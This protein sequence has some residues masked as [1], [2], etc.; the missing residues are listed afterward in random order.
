MLA[1]LASSYT[2]SGSK[3]AVVT[4]V[5]YSAQRSPSAR[6]FKS[7][8]AAMRRRPRSGSLLF[9]IFNGHDCIS[10]RRHAPEA[11]G[12]TRTF[13]FGLAEGSDSPTRRVALDS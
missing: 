2:S 7:L 11:G 5:R 13:L 1:F 12:Q 8:K 3:E 9:V 4:I 10:R 6:P